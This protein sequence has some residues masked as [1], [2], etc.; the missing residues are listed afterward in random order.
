[1]FASVCMCLLNM[2][3]C[4]TFFFTFLQ[5]YETMKVRG[6]RN[7]LVLSQEIVRL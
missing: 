7:G 2:Y 3:T 4:H 6:I 5:M 1:M